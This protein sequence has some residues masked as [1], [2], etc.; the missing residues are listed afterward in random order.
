MWL[1]EQAGG[2]GTYEVSFIQYWLQQFLY[3]D[4]PLWMFA[5]AYTLFGMAVAA[6]WYFVTHTKKFKKP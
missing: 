5:I 6:A 2:S 4:F 1:R 3:Y